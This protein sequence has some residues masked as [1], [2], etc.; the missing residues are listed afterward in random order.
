MV[1]SRRLRLIGSVALSLLLFAGMPALALAD[2]SPVDPAVAPHISGTVTNSTGIVSLELIS[3]TAED[4]GTHAIT[5]PVSTDDAGGYTLMVASGHYIVH[6]SDPHGHYLDGSY[7]ASGSNHLNMG[8]GTSAPVDVTAGSVSGVNVEMSLGVHL[9]GTVTGPGTPPNPLSGIGVAATSFDPFISVTTTTA[10]DGTFSLLVAANAT[11]TVIFDGQD[12]Y[13][14]QC[15]GLNVS[16][17]LDDCSVV[18]VGG[19]DATHG[20]QLLLT[21]GDVLTI[22]PDGASVAAG[23]SQ[24]YKATL[25]NPSPPANQF[26]PNG[27]ISTADLS[28][29]TAGTT[30]SMVGGTCTGAVCTPTAQGDHAVSGTYGS[31]TSSVTLHATAAPATPTP[32][33]TA[34][35][36]AA[37]TAPPTSTDAPGSG[38][39]T[40]LMALFLMALTG[41]AVTL[42]TARR[43]LRRRS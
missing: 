9:T 32:V 39:G 11:Y 21:A 28:D 4:T 25:T 30:F 14:D 1:T 18:E 13:T 29:V 40:P 35:P 15:A 16:P 42:F 41:A 17:N 24:T 34:A 19:T 5:G 7:S 38:E 8:G 3:V 10:T 31:A 43:P 12:V 36:T 27:K 26:L 20:A 33:P 6:F 2:Q 37:P 22:T 23:S